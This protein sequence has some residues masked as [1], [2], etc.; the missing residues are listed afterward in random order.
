MNGRR[1]NALSAA[2]FPAA[3]QA[4]LTQEFA[5]RPDVAR[6]GIPDATDLESAI[7]LANACKAR[8]NEMIGAT[9]DAG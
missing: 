2:G 6:I 9:K 7:K 3:Q 1:A 8:L 5:S 4:A